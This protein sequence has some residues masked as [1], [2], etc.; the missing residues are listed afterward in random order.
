MLNTV[1]IGILN[2][3]GD[4]VKKPLVGLTCVEP[5]RGLHVKTISVELIDQLRYVID[6]VIYQRCSIQG[7]TPC[8]ASVIAT[9]SCSASA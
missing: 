5:E 6:L 2:Y 1:N 3:V 4:E 9:I 8:V 7:S